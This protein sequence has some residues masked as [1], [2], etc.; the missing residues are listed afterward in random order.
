[1][2][3]RTLPALTRTETSRRGSVWLAGLLPALSVPAGLPGLRG[4]MANADLLPHAPTTR[5]A[6]TLVGGSGL[7]NVGPPASPLPSPHLFECRPQSV[8]FVCCGIGQRMFCTPG[9]ATQCSSRACGQSGIIAPWVPL[10]T[11]SSSPAGGR[12]YASVRWCSFCF[13]SGQPGLQVSAQGR[14]LCT[15]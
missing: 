13:I 5:K 12:R 2:A 3:L 11:S 15:E 1:M 6:S 14:F 10:P 7:R 9:K 4:G 8:L